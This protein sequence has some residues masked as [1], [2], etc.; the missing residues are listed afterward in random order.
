MIKSKDFLQ[1]KFSAQLC[2]SMKLKYP[3]LGTLFKKENNI[4]DA[5]L[6]RSK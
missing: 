2:S 3:K 1:I 6:G 4:I 5:E